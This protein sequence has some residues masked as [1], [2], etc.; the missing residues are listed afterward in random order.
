MKAVVFHGPEDV[1]VE[2][3]PTP[4]CGAGELLVKVDACAVCGS[5]MKTFHH[6]NPRVTPPRVMGHEFTGLIET[7]GDGVEGYVSALSGDDRVENF[8]VG[9]R[10]VMATSV[11]CGKCFYCTLMMPNLC[12]DL[13]AMGFGYDGGMAEY[14]V[15]PERA[16]RR[17]HV[18]KVPGRVAPEHAALAEP[19]SCAVNACEDFDYLTGAGVVLVVGAGPMGILNACVA[20][21]NCARKVI[22]A[23]INDA[24][25]NQC[26]PFGFDRL[27]N[28]STEDLK[29]VVMEETNGIGADFVI[30]AAPAA[31]PQEQALELVRK[32]GTICLFASLPVGKSMLSL[33]SRLIHYNELRVIGS[34][35]SRPDQVE[36]AVELLT[37]GKAMRADLIASHIRTLD[38]IHEAFGLMESGEALRVVLKP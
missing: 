23:E 16:L 38:D 8:S 21:E 15:I 10:V 34:S 25:L 19:V 29:A 5:D 22:V 18:L 2:D 33:D 37:V 3:V 27:V 1:R 20:R 13:K 14:V 35:D 7:V 9:D 32:Q 17:G 36:R 30:V 28:P 11:S 4:S 6:G 26:G 31:A 24:R 12:L